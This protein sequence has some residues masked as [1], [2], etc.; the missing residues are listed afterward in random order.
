VAPGSKNLLIHVWQ[1]YAKSTNLNV[2]IYENGY[3]I[4]HEVDLPLHEIIGDRH[5]QEYYLRYISALCEAVRDDHGV[6]MAGCHC[7]SLL[8]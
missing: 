8:E 5:R 4:E 6:R 3:A 1:T 7:W 2:Y